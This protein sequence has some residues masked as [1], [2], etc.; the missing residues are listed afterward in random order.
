MLLRFLIR[1][2][3]GIYFAAKIPGR[4]CQMILGELLWTH[5]GKL[6]GREILKLHCREVERTSGCVV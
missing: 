4:D 5:A 3:V 1:S 6:W 2:S